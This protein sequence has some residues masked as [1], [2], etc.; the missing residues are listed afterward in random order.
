MSIFSRFFGKQ[1]DE[2]VGE[3]V[4]NPDLDTDS[5][6]GLQILFKGAIP[7]DSQQITRAM[8]KLNPAM[9]HARCDLEAGLANEDKAFGLAGWGK[10]VI[11]ILGFDAPM[12]REAVSRCIEC[13]PY[14]DEVKQQAFAHQGHLLLWY[15]GYDLDPLNQ[16]VALGMLAGALAQFGAVVI[17]NESSCASVPAALMTDAAKEK[18]DQI[19]RYL[20]LNLLYCGIVRLEL[21]GGELWART[22]GAHL[23]NLPDLAINVTAKD[24]ASQFYDFVSDIFPY[25]MNS[26][27]TIEAGHTMQVAE[28]V[29]IR[30]KKPGTDQQFLDSPGRLLVMEFIGADEINAV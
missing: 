12:P 15:R 24:E 18:D 1:T 7:T 14:P 21:E 28:A 5:T 16:Y 4:A 27:S 6:L 23:L 20:P 29:F 25:M 10:H 8:Q 13:G 22:C 26:G 11:Q 3:L 30:V 19:I 2:Q 9:S 17:I